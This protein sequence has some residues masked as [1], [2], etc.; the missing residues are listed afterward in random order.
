MKHHDDTRRCLFINAS[1]SLHLIISI[2]CSGSNENRDSETSQIQY[3]M[4]TI[5]AGT[6]YTVLVK[7]DGTLWN[8]GKK[9]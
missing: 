5:T 4:T 1:V 8:W 2:G 7:T 6:D 9:R 3:M